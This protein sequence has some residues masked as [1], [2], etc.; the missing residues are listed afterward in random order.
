MKR[1]L[2]VL[3]FGWSATAVADS[4]KPFTT[5]GCSAFPNGTPR[6]QSLWMDC[7]I[8]HDLAYWMGGTREERRDADQALRQC[9]ADIGEEEIAEIMLAGVRVGGSP[10]WPTGYRWGYGW[11]YLRGY[12][13]LSDEEVEAVHQRLDELRRLLDRLDAQLAAPVL[14]E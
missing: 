9:V 10:Y 7:C 8:Q 5:D 13:A 4:L 3:L 6:Q 12:E 2:I 1:L 11:G 14:D